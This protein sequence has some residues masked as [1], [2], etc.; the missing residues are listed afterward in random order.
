MVFGIITA[1]FLALCLS[2]IFMRK[3]KSKVFHTL[4][5]VFGIAALITCALHFALTLTL[6]ESRPLSIWITGVLL[7]IILLLL[8]LSG[9][10]KWKCWIKWH[11][12]LTIALVI[13]L[14]SHVSFNIIALDNYKQAA[15]SISLSDVDVDISKISDGVYI[16]ECD[17]G[18]VY[19]KVRVTVQYGEI[20]NVEILEHRT[21][22]GQ[23]AERIADDIIDGQKITVD[24]VSSATN[25]SNVIKNAVYNALMGEK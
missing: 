19:A 1:V 21:E 4:H 7:L 15:V 6:F 18:Y 25:S 17:I 5:I 8:I 20:T 10:L 16:G 3:S 13:A 12:V 2:K 14:I 9:A 24:A 11:R 23:A 22:R